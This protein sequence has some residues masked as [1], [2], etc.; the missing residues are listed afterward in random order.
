MFSTT[1]NFNQM[2]TVFGGGYVQERHSDG[3]HHYLAPAEKHEFI[4]DF[5]AVVKALRSA[6]SLRW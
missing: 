5:D 6:L 3:A 2:H 1:Q 4:V